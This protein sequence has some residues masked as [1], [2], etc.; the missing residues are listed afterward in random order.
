M[1]IDGKTFAK[2]TLRGIGFVT[3]VDGA[4]TE[5]V[6]RMKHKSSSAKI[7]VDRTT[8]KTPSLTALETSNGRLEDFN[9]LDSRDT[10][11]NLL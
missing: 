8:P 1:R 5:K 11:I 3:F 9:P 7:V 4:S 6:V 2:N 10:T